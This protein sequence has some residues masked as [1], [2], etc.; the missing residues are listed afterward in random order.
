[1]MN[2]F[3][4]WERKRRLAESAVEYDTNMGLMDNPPMP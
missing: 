4:Q 1:M 3:N 2:G